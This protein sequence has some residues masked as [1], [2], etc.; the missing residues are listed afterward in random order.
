[1]RRLFY[2]IMA[3]SLLL[4]GCDDKKMMS[5]TLPVEFITDALPKYVVPADP[6]E[7]YSINFRLESP[8]YSS[9]ESDQEWCHVKT[10]CKDGIYVTLTADRNL[11]GMLRTANITI[12]SPQIKGNYVIEVEQGAIA[13]DIANLENEYLAEGGE[14]VLNV[15]STKPWTL[16]S[17]CDWLTFDKTSGGSTLETG[18]EEVRLTVKPNDTG[19]L[20]FANVK[21]SAVSLGE[22]DFEIYQEEPW[23]TEVRV[24][25]EGVTFDQGRF[26]SNYPQIQEWMKAG[27]EGGIPPLE[28]Q[29][30]S[31]ARIFSPGEEEEFLAYLETDK[32]TTRAI[33]LKNGT[34]KFTKSFRI[35]S[36][37][38][39]VGESRD[40]VVIE[41]SGNAYI[42]MYNGIKAG[43]RNL[44]IVG[45]WSDKDPDPTLM[46]E[47]I[48]GKGD[49]RTIDIGGQSGKVHD[50]FVDGVTI[51]NSASHPIWI[52]ASHNTIRD[53]KIDGAYNK[54]AGCQGYFFIDGDHNLITGC[55]VTHIRHISMQNPTSKY[56][57]FYKNN[58]R[59]E[60]SFHVNDGGDNLVEHNKITIPTT[61][62]GYVAIM[63]PWST[64]HQVGGKNFVY[65]NRCLEE[66]HNNNTPWSD[67]EL[68]IGPW[69]VL[70]GVNYQQHYT[71]FRVTEDYPKPI[72]RT[73]YPVIL[74]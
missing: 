21:F 67:N 70:A 34:Y 45:K 13:F 42:N 32:Y 28:E 73:L 74:K 6:D 14:Y 54:G 16:E 44:T 1:M 49:H 66:N 8:Y 4:G 71:N 12:S 46:E 68:Y 41:L 50:N 26:D 69:E 35:Y 72:G 60:F 38:T 17:D 40:G 29:L 22:R 53:V 56:N 7:N 52:S 63:G 23:E 24:G 5:S 55:E 33:L 43:I 10:T 31:P 58:V 11:T 3:F 61:L 57:V 36:N 64:Q 30:R 25:D 65:R 19:I 20:R 59:Q 15:S 48:P 9:V 18:V 51:I 39:L 47:V 37:N 27:K 62:S 2:C